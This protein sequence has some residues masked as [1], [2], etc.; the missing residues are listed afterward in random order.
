MIRSS[1]Q[2]LANRLGF[3]RRQVWNWRRSLWWKLVVFALFTTCHVWAQSQDAAP[4]SFE[5]ASIKLNKSGRQI[6]DFNIEPGGRFVATGITMG[7]L[8]QIA[9]N[10]KEFQIRGEPSWFDDERYDIEAKPNQ[11]FAASVANQHAGEASRQ[12]LKMLQ[13]LLAE[14]CKLVIEHESKE[15]SSYALVVAKNGPKLKS[16]N[17][18]PPAKLESPPLGSGDTAQGIWVRSRGYITS[19]GADMAAFAD[20]LSRLVG[21]YGSRQNGNQG[22]L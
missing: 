16:S 21:E 15:H 7:L 10:V 1:P 9:Y 6:V 4:P 2:L 22:L 8:F 12:V 13:S 5:V 18:E 3:G 17:L 20:M 19:T 11:S 14:R